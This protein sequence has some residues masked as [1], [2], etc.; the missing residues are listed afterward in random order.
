MD[1][2]VKV[3]NVDNF[4]YEYLATLPTITKGRG[5][6]AI[7]YVDIITGFDIETTNLDDISQ[8]I[9]YVWQF[10]CGLNYTVIGRR[11]EEYFTFLKRVREVIQNKLLVIYVH[12]LSF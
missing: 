10:Q 1:Q 4:P 3:L 5:K 9:M 6:N 2:T 8:S 11:W 7:E 12:N